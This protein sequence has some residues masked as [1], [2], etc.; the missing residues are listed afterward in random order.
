M[1]EF[2]DIQRLIRLKRFEQPE[3]GFTE[4]F[5]KQFHQRQREDMLKKSSVE[6]FM[7]R[8]ATWWAHLLVPKWSLAAA[9]VA[10][11]A[12]SFW[13]LSRPAE[14]RGAALTVVPAVPEKPFVP[15]L[16]LSDLPLARMAEKDKATLNDLLV[17]NHLEVRPIL[18]GKVSPETSPS[19][20][21][22]TGPD[23]P[24][25]QKATPAIQSGSEGLLGK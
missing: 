19:S 16:D 10:V 1:N 11:C 8:A 18:E 7:E 23:K 12:V 4:N 14:N 17:R 13:L 20:L 22:A 3:E 5:L 25:L 15:K 9:T 21:P 2:E 6:L 24:S